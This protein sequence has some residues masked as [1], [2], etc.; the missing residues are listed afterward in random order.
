META[1]LDRRYR[2]RTLIMMS[3]ELNMSMRGE[4]YEDTM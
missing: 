3:A 1:E 2:H 4:H